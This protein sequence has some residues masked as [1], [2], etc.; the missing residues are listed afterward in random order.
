[1]NLLLA[2]DSHETSSLNFFL[3]IKVKK[4]KKKNKSLVCCNF[5]LALQGLMGVDLI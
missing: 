1:M 2:E 5:Y 4:K 3:K